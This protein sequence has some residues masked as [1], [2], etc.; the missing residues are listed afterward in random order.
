[1]PPRSDPERLPNRFDVE[2][3]VERS[4]L[5]PI[6]RHIILVL[7]GRMMQGSTVIPPGHSPSL[8]KLA[9]GTG[10]DRRTIMRHLNLLEETGWLI[11]RRPDPHLARTQHVR[12]AYVVTAPGL[13]PAQARDTG[14]RGLGAGPAQARDT[15]TRGLGTGDPEARGRPPHSQGL[16]D[17]RTDQSGDL[18]DL[19]IKQLHERT[20]VTVT[21]EWAEKTRDLLLTRPGIRNERA[22]I[23]RTITTDPHPERWLPTPEPPPYHREESS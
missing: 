2:R 23:I 22:Y 16:S 9:E 12:T 6:G 1:L 19:V 13:G 8:T 10:W 3:A 14:T 11:R 5:E 20:G 7:C 17:E 21:H 4:D 18:A 15:G